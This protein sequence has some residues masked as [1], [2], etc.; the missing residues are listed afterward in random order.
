M[1]DTCMQNNPAVLVAWQTITQF[2]GS[3]KVYHKTEN[4]S[5]KLPPSA[6]FLRNKSGYCIISPLCRSITDMVLSSSSVAMHF[7]CSHVLS[8]SYPCMNAF[9]PC[10]PACG[11]INCI[12]HTCNWLTTGHYH[13]ITLVSEWEVALN[14]LDCWLLCSGLRNLQYWRSSLHCKLIYWA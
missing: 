8:P 11:W 5:I 6:N 2:F 9:T 13:I 7:I 1:V 12:P 3:T 14:G 4:W 10:S